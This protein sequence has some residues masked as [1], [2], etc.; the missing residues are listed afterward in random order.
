MSYR[1][2]NVI[3]IEKEKEQQCDM[4]GQM[5]ELRR[6]GPNGACICFDCANSTPEM[7]EIVKKNMDRILFG[8]E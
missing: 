7:K 8:E 1:I 5:K 4:C 6:Y 3:V 2:G